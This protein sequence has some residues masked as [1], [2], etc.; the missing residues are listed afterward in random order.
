[1]QNLPETA[2]YAVGNEA[3]RQAAH[4]IQH[5]LDGIRADVFNNIVSRA[6]RGA[7]GTEIA[8]A[9]GISILTVR[10][11]CSELRDA[12][13][14]VDSGAM[15]KSS[16]E[17]FNETVWLVAANPPTGP[18]KAPGVRLADEKEEGPSGLEVFDDVFRRNP[19]LRN[20]FRMGEID[21][22]REDLKKAA[23]QS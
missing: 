17:D 21:T 19:H 3:S 15:R 8:E 14:I 4:G 23:V 18:W 11:R 16:D 1:M 22:I 10:P 13:Y 12:G 2:P 7:T 20:T 5:Q 6:R 9:T